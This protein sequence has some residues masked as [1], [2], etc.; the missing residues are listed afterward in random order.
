MKA[1]PDLTQVEKDKLE[2]NPD[3][4]FREIAKRPF[5]DISPNELAM[6]KWSGVYH[7]LQPSFFMIRVVTPG[8]RMTTKQFNRAVDLGEKYAQDEMCITTRQTLQ[9]HWIRKEDIY[10]I[11]EGMAEV[12]ITSKNGCGDVPRNIIGDSLAGAG[13]NQIGDSLK[14]IRWMAD[15]DEIQNQRNLP[16]K[17]KISV[18]SSNDALAQT[19]MNCQGW[20]P[21]ERD[22]VVGW[23]YHAGGGLGARPYLA[24]AIFDWVPEDLVMA[25]TRAAIEA[26]RRHGDRRHR[27]HSRLKVVVDQMGA[28]K[29]GDVLIDIMK[30][31]NVQGLDSIEFAASAV[32][33]IGRMSINGE[34]VIPQKTEGKS[35]VRILIPRSEIKTPESRIISKLA[36]ELGG[37]II[38]FT[39]RQNIE[40]HDVPNEN[41][42]K[43]V[44]ALHEAGFKTEGH[45]HLPDIVACVGTTMCKMAVSDSPD[46]YHRLYNALATDETYWKAIGTLRINITGC[47]NNCAHAWVADIGLRGTRT[48][49]PE[50]GSVE[51]YSV[52]VGGKL[53]EDGKI[54]EYLCDAATEEIVP[55][56]KKILD[57]YLANRQ[58][59]GE[60]FVDFCA[61]IGISNFQELVASE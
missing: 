34:A 25:V 24:K 28:K 57:A 9:Y 40:L 10:K 46:A 12:G 36:D 50:G 31:K 27:A 19:L 55:A 41:A 33:N 5:E 11:I 35:I 26:F 38:M 48:R 49:N 8:G 45:E 2:I 47:P 39:N 37:G 13:P 21:V 7:Q 22:G 1:Q 14:L 6:F 29:F 23:K 54:A 60:L 44:A 17:H 16:R 58:S 51:G 53:S 52:F 61:R 30:E 20:V 15:D 4:D 32:P 56:V 43:L 42:D 3:F 59:D 18:A